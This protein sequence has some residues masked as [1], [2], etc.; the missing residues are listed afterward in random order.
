MY[1]DAMK[2]VMPTAAKFFTD[3]H[4]NPAVWQLPN[5]PLIT[6]FIAGAAAHF[7]AAGTVHELAALVSF[8][9]LFTWS[10]LEIAAGSSWFRRLLGAAVLGYMLLSRVL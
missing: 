9:A 1:T 8:G 10:W 5:A 2:R 4:G 3:E 7:I 6:A